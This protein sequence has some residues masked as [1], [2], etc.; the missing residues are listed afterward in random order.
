MLRGGFLRLGNCMRSFRSNRRRGIRRRR[1]FLFF[2]HRTR[3]LS[4]RQVPNLLHRDFR[5]VAAP[6][7]RLHQIGELNT[8]AGIVQRL[9]KRL[10]LRGLDISPAGDVG[11]VHGGNKIGDGLGVISMQIDL[12]LENG[13]AVRDPHG[14]QDHPAVGAGQTEPHFLKPQVQLQHRLAGFA[15]GGLAKIPQ[16]IELRHFPQGLG[17]RDGF[18]DTVFHEKN[19]L[20]K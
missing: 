7:F 12:R 18:D 1:R 19:S 14:G 16:G 9:I 15:R 11:C 10:V 4:F 20:Q 17:R 2:R 8:E 3:G 13:H 6:A 5:A